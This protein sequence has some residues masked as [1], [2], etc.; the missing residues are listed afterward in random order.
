MILVCASS[1][2]LFLVQMLL[3][4][5][6]NINAAR[7]SDGA[8][9]LFT[10]A[11]N[12]HLQCVKVK[13]GDGVEYKHHSSQIVVFCYILSRDVTNGEKDFPVCFKSFSVPYADSF[14]Y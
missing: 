6:A 13:V 14:G 7:S 10:A 2:L 1:I 8:T 4:I 3:A 9:P 11:E 5:G 12:G